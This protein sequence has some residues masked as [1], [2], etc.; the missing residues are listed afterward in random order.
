[1]AASQGLRGVYEKESVVRG[2]HVYK[3]SW[4]PVI[5][6]EL[7]LET[8]DDNEDDEHTVAVMK[9]GDIVGHVAR[10]ISNVSSQEC[11]CALGLVYSF[12]LERNVITLSLG[13]LSIDNAL[14]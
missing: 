3:I 12:K 2:H 11:L 13:H 8:E 5:G 7:M 9:D 14:T 1:M 6:E 10:S 4:T